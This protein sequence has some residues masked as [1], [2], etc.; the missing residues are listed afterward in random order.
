MNEGWLLPLLLILPTLFA[1]LG[2]LAGSSRSAIRL[3]TLGTLLCSAAAVAAAIVALR[4][5]HGSHSELT[6]LGAWLMLDA[7]SAYHLLVMA[8]VFS[9]SG[10]Y[11]RTYFG[12]DIIDGSLSLRTARRF[13]ALWFG[14]LGAMH[15]VLVSNNLG[16]MWVGIEATTLLTAFLICIHGTPTSLEAMWKY[17]LMCSVGVALAFMGTLLVA[18]ST[19]GSGIEGSSALLWT[20][21]RDAATRL[22]PKLLKIGFLFLVVGYGTKAGLAPMHNWLPDAHSQAPAPVSAIFSGFLLNAALYCILRTLPLVESLP[23]NAGW[24]REILVAFGLISILVAAVFI[25]AQ[26]DVKRLLAYSS[27]EHLGIIALGVGLGGFGYVA[28]LFHIFNNSVSKSVGFFCAGSIGKIAGTHDMRR[29]NRV[30][31][32]SPVWGGGLTGSLLAIIG[33]APFSLFL[34]EFLILHTAVSQGH[35]YIA[36][37]FLVGL[38]LVFVGAL[39][40]LISITWEPLDRPVE[41]HGATLLE[42]AIVFVPLASLLMLGVFVPAPFWHVLEKAARILGGAS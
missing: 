22:N 34:S 30:T 32:L 38:A 8:A 1:G 17:L 4:Q 15:L 13:T 5:S 31:A 6:A 9:L 35:Y 14:A 3:L 11:A 28:A 10:L 29:I 2:L 26:H 20:E 12:P 23:G 42:G 39:R 21:L 25:I 33:A 37:V 41:P 24:G 36:A 40:H 19:H 7:L 27:V 16:L 18:A